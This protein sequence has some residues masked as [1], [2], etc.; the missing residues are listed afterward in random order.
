MRKEKK[1]RNK[2]ISY[3]T[4][5]LRILE[6]VNEFYVKSILDCFGRFGK[7]RVVCYDH[8][9]Y[10]HYRMPKNNDLIVEDTLELDRVFS[11]RRTCGSRGV[12]RGYS[13][14]VGRLGRIDEEKTCEFEEID[15][16]FDK[17]LRDRSYM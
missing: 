1:G 16:D 6:K 17:F 2:F 12:R 8:V 14:G 9:P 11:L 15:D 13:I 4:A 3:V 5:P 10:H 7:R